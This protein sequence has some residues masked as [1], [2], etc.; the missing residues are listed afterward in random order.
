[1]RAFVEY[2]HGIDRLDWLTADR[3]TAEDANTIGIGGSVDV[4][5]FVTLGGGYDYQDR[6]GGSIQRGRAQLTVRF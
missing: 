5:P 6:T 4:T 3:L 1:V 2:R